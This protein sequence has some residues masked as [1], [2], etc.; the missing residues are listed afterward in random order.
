MYYFSADLSTI[1]IEIIKTTISI[2]EIEGKS[3]AEVQEFI[4]N[5]FV[6]NLESKKADA[7]P[8]NYKEF[9]KRN[10]LHCPSG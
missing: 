5:I 6:T 7:D 2:N 8:E 9:L 4:Y 1:K 3:L 10:L